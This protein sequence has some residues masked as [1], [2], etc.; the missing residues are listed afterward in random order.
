MLVITASATVF[1]VYSDSRVLSQS[2]MEEFGVQVEM[3]EL[4][5]PKD[6]RRIWITVTVRPVGEGKKFRR[7][8]FSVLEK[9]L[10]ADFAST[11]ARKGGIRDTK[12][13]AKEIRGEIIEKSFLR[14]SVSDA[15]I[16]CGYIVVHFDLPKDAGIAVFGTY[17]LPLAEIKSEA[18][19]PS[20]PT[21]P[22]RGSS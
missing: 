1:M 11:D 21:R 10:D 2:Q 4:P 6:A 14:F 18:N 19:Q 9:A 20:E 13:W 7:L 22:A 15:E 12:K 16:P 8:G 5:G 3:V 17:Y